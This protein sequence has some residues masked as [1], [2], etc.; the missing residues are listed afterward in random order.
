MIGSGSVIKVNNGAIL[1]L[2]DSSPAEA[3]DGLPCGGVLTGG[4]FVDTGSGGGVNVAS[5]FF[6]MNGGNIYCCT[7][8]DGGGVRIGGSSFGYDFKMTGGVIENCAASSSGD[9]VI[10]GAVTTFSADG[11]IIVGTVALGSDAKIKSGSSYCTRF[12]GAVES[13]GTIS[14]GIYYGGIPSR[15][16]TEGN[17]KTVSFNLNGGEGYVPTQWFF[18]DITA[19]ILSPANPTKVGY[20][21][22]DG[23]YNGDTKYNFTQPVPGNITLTAKFS[24]P[25]TYTISCN[26]N[27]G[28]ATNPP[29]YTAES[30]TITLN[31]PEKPGDIF[32]GWSGTGL[33]G[34]N[35][36]TVTISKGSTGNREYTAHW[37][38]DTYEITY[39]LNDG[40]AP[41]S[42]NPTS[43][44]VESEAI[45]L[46]NPTKTGYSF[47]GWN[48]TGINGRDLKYVIIPKGSTGNREYAADWT[49]E[50]YVVTLNTNGGKINSGNV[51]DYT[52]GQG[53]TLPTDVTKAGYTFKGWYDNETFTGDPVATIS[54][55]DTEKR[56][57]GRSGQQLV[58]LQFRRSLPSRPAKVLRLP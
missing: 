19:M 23:W 11:G 30:E 26:L 6:T 42:Q 40:E 36:M 10:T 7:A 5:G 54:D 22:F 43:Y 24:S 41:N 25:T 2:Q 1:T 14:G 46:N 33:S 50:M 35:N 3:H 45:E 16:N 53:A 29:S 21:S 15:V 4:I 27:G 18:N 12:Y 48:G 38:Q 55:T 57:I 51:T 44:T 37:T 58:I 56:N 17:Y 8:D 31:N 20:Q 52:Y 49:P 32:T 47:T 9:A 13:G 28:A 34:T 39:L